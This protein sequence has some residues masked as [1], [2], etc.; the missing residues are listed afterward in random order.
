MDADP[1]IPVVEKVYAAAREAGVLPFLMSGS[2]LG[3]ARCGGPLPGDRDLDFGIFSDDYWPTKRVTFLRALFAMGARYTQ[4]WRVSGHVGLQDTVELD[5]VPVDFHSC[6]VMD[7]HRYHFAYVPVCDTNFEMLWLL[8][9]YRF[10][11]FTIKPAIF[12]GVE[13]M[14]PDPLP[15]Y[16]TE[17]FGPTYIEPCPGWH[18]ARSAPNCRIVDVLV[19]RRTEFVE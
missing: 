7:S 5:G 9:E 11:L 12:G 1:K 16:L 3:L 18:W 8:A 15:H 13:V 17:H 10:T 4:G 14:A 19:S 6:P 2:A